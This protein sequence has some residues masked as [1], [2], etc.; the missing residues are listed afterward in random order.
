MSTPALGGGS[1]GKSVRSGGE[2][3]KR[4]STG[5]SS[6]GERVDS[7]FA[8][9]SPNLSTR[10]GETANQALAFGL[11][12][13]SSAVSPRPE[14]PLGS[15]EIRPPGPGLGSESQEAKGKL[16]QLSVKH[17]SLA[18]RE[19]DDRLCP[20]VCSLDASTVGHTAVG[21][22]VD[23]FTP[24]VRKLDDRLRPAACLSGDTASTVGLTA[25][26]AGVDFIHSGRP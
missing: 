11:V 6:K 13:R 20:A 2:G 22:G 4:S 21:T 7:A 1:R 18:V 17:F 15:L 25:D 12:A 23:L 26:C 14:L 19:L 3:R 16:S 24:A 9:P 5:V 10:P 8:G